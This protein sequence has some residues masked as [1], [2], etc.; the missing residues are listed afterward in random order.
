MAGEAENLDEGLFVDP[1]CEGASGTSPYEETLA[2]VRKALEFQPSWEWRQSQR[3]RV[4]EFDQSI[5][6]IGVACRGSAE[7]S[8]PAEDKQKLV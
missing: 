3:K 1:D 2:A 5:E 4:S 8:Q 7:V 6:A